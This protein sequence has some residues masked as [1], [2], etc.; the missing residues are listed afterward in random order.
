MLTG[1]QLC[2]ST[3]KL[4]EIYRY[5]LSIEKRSDPEMIAL[6]PDLLP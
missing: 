2:S 1:T 4:N 5:I 3:N 6:I